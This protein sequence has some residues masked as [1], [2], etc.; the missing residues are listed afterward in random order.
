MDISQPPASPSSHPHPHPSTVFASLH[1]KSRSI[2]HTPSPP[3]P[4]PSTSTATTEALDTREAAIRSAKRYLLTLIRDD[5]SFDRHSFPLAVARSARKRQFPTYL[6]PDGEVRVRE[7]CG[8]REREVDS[9]CEEGGGGVLG[10]G[11]RV[12]SRTPDPY[13]FE[14]PDAVEESVVERRARRRRAV[15]EEMGWNEGL[16]VWVERRDAWTGARAKG[17]VDGDADGDGDGD[18]QM[19]SEDSEPAQG[20][21]EMQE[22]QDTSR[23]TSSSSVK[24]PPG[25]AIDIPNANANANTTTPSRGLLEA[26]HSPQPDTNP[27]APSHTPH[28]HPDPN[29]NPDTDTD[30]D[31]DP[32]EPLVPLVT[33]LLPA[34]NPIRASIKP[35]LYPSIYSKVVIQSLTPAIPINLSD[36]TKALVQGWKADGEWPPRPTVSQ[37]VPVVKKRAG[38][39]G[40]VGGAGGRGAGGGGGGARGEAGKSRRLSG[41]SVTGAVK[42]VLGFG[43]IH[44]GKRFHIRGSSHGGGA[45]TGSSPPAEQKGG[46]AG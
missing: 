4:S 1:R 42:K 2:A 30:T 41:S 15:R 26:P 36:V 17:G 35:T 7:V 19:V 29:P 20:L 12:T 39:N 28:P 25:V 40:A 16:R 24:V 37:D 10:V 43:G 32:T 13:R 34:T 18:V 11:Q 21:D 6:D 27:T 31:T 14:S 46:L 8:W 38:N 44:P 22:P 45:G 23:P 3:S 9:S 5:W 33:P